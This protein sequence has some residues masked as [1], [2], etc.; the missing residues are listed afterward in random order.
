MINNCQIC[1]RELLTDRAS[2]RFLFFLSPHLIYSL[3]NFFNHSFEVLF[4]R[5]RSKLFNPLFG[6]LQ[7]Y[8]IKVY[9]FFNWSL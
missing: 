6:F 5:R 1:K 9:R 4:F 3:V 8:T 2:E 7:L